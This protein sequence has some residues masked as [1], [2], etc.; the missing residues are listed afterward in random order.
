MSVACPLKCGYCEKH[1]GKKKKMWP[2]FNLEKGQKGGKAELAQIQ[3][4]N[5][6]KSFRKLFWK[7]T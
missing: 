4:G 5:S 3:I 6:L 2:I 7:A 1:N